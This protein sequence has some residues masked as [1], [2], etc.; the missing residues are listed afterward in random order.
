MVSHS[1][2]INPGVSI[3]DAVTWFWNHGAQL[4]DFVSFTF[5]KANMSYTDYFPGMNDTQYMTPHYEVEHRFKMY[6]H[7]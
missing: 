1:D 7:V 3:S 4:M 6:V 2:L 5:H